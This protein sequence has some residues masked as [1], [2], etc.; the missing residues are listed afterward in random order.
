MRQR[1]VPE[2]PGFPS[3]LVYAEALERERQARDPRDAVRQHRERARQLPRARVDRLAV[4]GTGD[5]EGVEDAMDHGVREA[6]ERRGEDESDD[7]RGD[8]G[9]TDAGITAAGS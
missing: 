1:P 7:H 8:G 4:L 3:R 2:Q 6:R 5:V 9:V